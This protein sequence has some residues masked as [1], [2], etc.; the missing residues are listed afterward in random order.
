MLV[1]IHACSGV[2]LVLIMASNPMILRRSIVQMLRVKIHSTREFG[3]DYKANL[4]DFISA[5]RTIVLEKTSV[6]SNQNKTKT[7]LT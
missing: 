5:A 2:G 4:T 3:K 6:A 1:R 7:K